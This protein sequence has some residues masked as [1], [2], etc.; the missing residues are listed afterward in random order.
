MSRRIALLNLLLLL[1]LVTGPS[2]S[3]A[4]AGGVNQAALIVRHVDGSIQTRCLT[5]TEPSI[6]GE[7]LLRR[8]GLTVIVNYSSGLGGAVCSINGDGCQYPVQDCFCHCQ[9]IQCE[10]WAYYHWAQGGWQYSSVGATG[11]QVSDGMLEG[12]SWG[13]GD[14]GTSG[15][16]PPQIGFSDICISPTAT[17]TPTATAS[18]T[19]TATATPTATPTVSSHVSSQPTAGRADAP[20]Q[21]TFEAMAE[22]VA[23]GACTVLKWV[24][25]DAERITLDGE[26]VMAQDRHEVCPSSTHTY[27]LAAANTSGQTVRE[28]TIQVAVA[29]QVV[30]TEALGNLPT[31]A[32]IQQVSASTEVAPLPTIETFESPLDASASAIVPLSAQPQSEAPR[33]RAEALTENVAPLPATVTPMALVTP[34]PDEASWAPPTP[35]ATPTVSLRRR[36]AGAGG[37]SPTPI[38]IALA[39][40][41]GR[42]G[43][44]DVISSST[45]GLGAG[46]SAP[47]RFDA[48]TP[49]NR[50]FSLSLM[51]GYASYLLMIALLLGGGA[52][53][54]RRR[55]IHRAQRS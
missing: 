55:N 29:G 31:P 50:D 30:P 19:A 44:Q 45:S 40:S 36:P 4:G 6:T 18:P 25:W 24:S 48:V 10:Y 22:T 26:P 42:T 13:P 15:T 37:P 43:F 16:M 49:L 8:S 21:V 38:L 28:L 41:G 51:P 35:F 2:P 1:A 46:Q 53:V 11:Y 7:E 52:W 33:P 34:G 9:G 27:A 3:N 39:S 12:W 32:E 23:S 47:S 17:P 14:Y 5:F 54:L 20:P